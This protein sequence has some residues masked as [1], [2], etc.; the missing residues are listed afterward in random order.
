MAFT[1]EEIRAN[2]AFQELIPEMKRKVLAH[3]AKARKAP[4]VPAR[5]GQDAPA[6]GAPPTSDEPNFFDIF[7]RPG[8][9]AGAVVSPEFRRQLGPGA[10]QGF[11]GLVDLTSAAVRWMGGE[12][13]ELGDEYAAAFRPDVPRPTTRKGKYGESV[14]EFIGENAPFVIGTGG[15]GLV[16]KGAV[17]GAK[18]AVGEVAAGVGA[19]AGAEAGRRATPDSILGPIIG[20]ILGGVGGGVGAYRALR[21]GAVKGA[22]EAAEA[23]EAVAKQADEVPEEV[24]TSAEN[25]ERAA[26]FRRRAANSDTPEEAA[27]HT[28]S[29]EEIEGRLP[30]ETV[31]EVDLPPDTD[32]GVLD[33]DRITQPMHAGIV[34]AAEELLTVGG[35]KRSGM[36]ISDQIADLIISGRI[37]GDDYL[38]ILARNNVDPDEFMLM[39]RKN[40]KE[41]A[42]TLQRL[43]AASAKLKKFTNLTDDEIKAAERFGVGDEF[44]GLNKFQKFENFRRGLLVSQLATAMRNAATQAGRLG[45]DVLQQGM[46]AGIRKMFPSLKGKAEP[47]AVDGLGQLARIFRPF[48]TKKQLDQVGD[49]FPK[50]YDRL[51][52]SHSS[53]VV[54][55]GGGGKLMRS[56]QLAVNTLNWANRIQ[57][58]VIRR[59]VFGGDLDRRL[60][61]HGTTIE[62]ALADG[63]LWK[64]RDAVEGAADRA[65][66]AT[67]AKRFSRH[68]TG[69]ESVA[70]SIIHAMGKTGAT[71]I[72]PFPRFMMNS[73]KFQY[74]YSPLPLMK[75]LVSPK[76]WRKIGAGNLDAITKGT[77][78][79]GLLLSAMQFRNSEYAG[80]RWYQAKNP[81]TG[82]LYDL[83]AYN[84]FATYMFVAEIAKRMHDGTMQSFDSR[85]LFQGVL[86][87]NLRAGAGLFMVDQFL[88]SI[89]MVGDADPEKWKE[90]LG[91]ALGAYAGSFSVPAQTFSDLY[92]G[93][94]QFLNGENATADI[95]RERKQS[96]FAPFLGRIPG[97]QEQL[98]E[99][100]SP[101][102][103]P[104]LRQEH[105]IARQLTGISSR[106]A[107]TPA[108]E[109]VERKGLTGKLYSSSG[110]REWDQL[111]SKHMGPLMDDRISEYV[112]RP[113]YL[114]MDEATQLM[115]LTERIGKFK[116]RAE[117]LARRESPELYK[118]SRRKPTRGSRE[119]LKMK[120]RGQLP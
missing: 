96:P 73:L 78:G 51:T 52:M 85:D 88:E 10:A 56:S 49:I 20:G 5:V 95:I 99:L 23:G 72:M 37:S 100:Q 76:E 94:D 26:Y 120:R 17:R 109:E 67:F 30:P 24:A 104:P 46:D 3:A 102:T 92:A 28:A 82:E 65:L 62:K 16:A 89:A 77:I 39:W 43:S 74:D 119:W 117:N 114:Q 55:A 107:M 41:G 9:V 53:D 97:V 116:Q 103:G 36:L 93:L 25:V 106:P 112:Q 59:A 79:T 32:P 60:R 33:G 61:F 110:N 7:T 35:V 75:A 118:A 42:Q 66:D 14:G 71:T 29:A 13:F 84:P 38:E 4:P 12:G 54:S 86:G 68:G 90:I 15:F 69:S 83:R 18:L 50:D 22:D 47:H 11:G 108:Q 45:L 91:G 81:T 113:S 1:D 101:E 34:T 27:R 80:P 19:E 48:K 98:P 44:T 70:G 105:P 2:P 58:F 87:A 21:K 8:E 63:S 111:V 31:V 40:V 64:Y 57:E 6:T 115:R